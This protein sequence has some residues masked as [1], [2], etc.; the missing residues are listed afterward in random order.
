MLVSLDQPF[1]GWPA[2][3]Q[4][5]AADAYFIANDPLRGALPWPSGGPLPFTTFTDAGWVIW[6]RVWPDQVVPPPN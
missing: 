4:A 3:G 1:E 5:T 6:A 2:A